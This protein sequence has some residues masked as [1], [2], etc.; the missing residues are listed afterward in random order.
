MKTTVEIYRMEMG[1]GTR[2]QFR[3]DKENDNRRAHLTHLAQ[4]LA[5]YPKDNDNIGSIDA[6][7][8]GHEITLWQKQADPSLKPIAF[9]SRFLND[10]EKNYAVG[11][12]ELLAVQRELEKFR[13]YF[14]GSKLLL[15][16]DHQ[17]LEPL[18]QRNRCNKQYNSR[19][20][21]WLDRLAHFDISIQHLGRNNLNFIVFLSTNPIEGAIINI[22]TGQY[23]LILKYGRIFTNQSQ[24]A[25]DIKFTHERKTSNKSETK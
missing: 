1:N 20:T 12:L 10:S 3:N 24:S 23:E 2:K 25:P 17:A 9:G 8:T 4:G 11:E 6:S 22:L 18:I 7:K 15:Y 19:V 13:F 21:R 5:H 16:T 14:Y